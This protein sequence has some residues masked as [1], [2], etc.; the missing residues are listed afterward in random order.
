[1]VVF[2]PSPLDNDNSPPGGKRRSVKPAF[3]NAEVPGSLA[4]AV[5]EL[6]LE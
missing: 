2:L 4:Q 6:Q 3:P 1:M 5:T